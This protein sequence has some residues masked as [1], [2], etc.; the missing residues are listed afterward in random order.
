MIDAATLRWGVIGA[1]CALLLVAAVSDIIRRRIPNWVVLGLIGLY[2]LAL[3]FGVAPSG[4]LSGLGAAAIVLVVTY[5]LYHFGVIGA[6]DAKLFS[7]AALFLGLTNLASFALM[8]VLVGGLMAVGVLIVHPKRVM[9]GLTARGRAEGAG[10]GIPYGVAIAI[11]G[12]AARV[13]SLNAAGL[14]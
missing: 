9:R 2:A 10:R 8:T 7:A 6:G 5:G 1:F 13:V 12:I 14:G 11:G 4:W 3:V